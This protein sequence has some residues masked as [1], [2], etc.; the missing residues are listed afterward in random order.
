MTSETIVPETTPNEA[1][2]RMLIGA[3]VRLRRDVLSH[4]VGTRALVVSTND[5]LLNDLELIVPGYPIKFWVPSEAVD[6]LDPPREDWW[7]LLLG[8]DEPDAA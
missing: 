7:A 8:K 6:V 3:V 4:A 1:P 2:P 5:R